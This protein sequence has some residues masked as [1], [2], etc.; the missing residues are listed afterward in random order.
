V[1]GRFLLL[2]KKAPFRHWHSTLQ[3]FT[4]SAIVRRL[5]V[6]VWSTM[7][8][9]QTMLPSPSNSATD[10]TFTEVTRKASPATHPRWSAFY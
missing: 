8:L 10:G 5:L 7:P 3:L 4:M 1:E 9:R 6:S 2:Q